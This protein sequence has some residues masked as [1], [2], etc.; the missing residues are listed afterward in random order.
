[1]FPSHRMC[2][3]LRMGWSF[4]MDTDVRH[5]YTLH[6]Y[7]L[8]KK[9]PEASA[10]EALGDLISSLALQ[11]MLTYTPTHAYY[12]YSHL[13][14]SFPLFPHRQPL[15]GRAVDNLCGS[16]SCNHVVVLG[17]C[18]F[19]ASAGICYKTIRLLLQMHY[20]H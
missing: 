19:K 14:L 3:C 1:M 8:Q 20:I 7:K 13:Y 17:T 4:G 16:Q 15:G 12:D 10:Y 5:A 9:L 6:V 2:I 11:I 18:H